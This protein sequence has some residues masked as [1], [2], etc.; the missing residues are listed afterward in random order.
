MAYR[1]TDHTRAKKTLTRDRLLKAARDLVAQGGFAAATAAAVAERSGVA[2]GSIYRHFPNK[3]ELVAEVFRYA[4]EHEVANVLAASEAL[5]ADDTC[6]ARL[7]RAVMT[8][9]ERALRG[10]QL[11][12]AL[13]AEPVDPR[14]EQERLQYRLAYAEIFEDLIRDGMNRG[15]FARQDASVSS[16]ALVGLLAEALIGPLFPGQN[17]AADA[18]SA[19]QA[20]TAMTGPEQQ[21]LIQQISALC[22][23]ALGSAH[24]ASSLPPESH[25]TRPAH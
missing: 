14:V 1:E 4:T 7:L 19:V 23:R 3:S 20:R 22:L 21:Q 5:S 24:P 9:A 11:A 13:I 12:Y 8:F 25:H 18:S 6:A 16:A 15:E 2:A 10:P 17:L